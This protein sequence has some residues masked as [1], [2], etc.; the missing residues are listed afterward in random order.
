M[1]FEML[2]CFTVSL[3]STA[4]V[5]YAQELSTPSTLATLQGMHGGIHNGLGE[6]VTLHQSAGTLH[7]ISQA[8][9]C[10]EC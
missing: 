4:S 6:A 3:M 9:L 10:Y 2:E 7:L 1:P 5:S 8:L